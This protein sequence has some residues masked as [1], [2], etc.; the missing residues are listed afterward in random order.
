D[1]KL[2]GYHFQAFKEAVTDSSWTTDPLGEKLKTD[3]LI[4]E[5]PAQIDLSLNL[6]TGFQQQSQKQ[7]PRIFRI[8]KRL[9]HLLTLG[10]YLNPFCR[11]VRPDGTLPFRFHGDYESWGWFGYSTLAVV[12]K[13]GFGYLC[14]RSWKEAMKLLFPCIS[15]S[16]RFL[17]TQKSMV[18]KYS[19]Q[20]GNYENAWREAFSVLDRKRVQKP[21]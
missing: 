11:S 20:S 14:K 9:A 5:N 21:S 2:A 12:D 18:R 7:G 15:L 4:R 8:A 10:N 13:N 19:Q 1:Y 17:V 3:A 16:I 6:P